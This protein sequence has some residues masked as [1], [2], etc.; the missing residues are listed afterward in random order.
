MLITGR[1]AREALLDAGISDR[2]A[3]TALSCGLAGPAVTT[4]AALL[5]ESDR[6][7]ELGR[8][9]IVTHE[10]LHER[11]PEGVFLTR[12]SVHV[13]CGPERLR[14]ELSTIPGQFSVLTMLGLGWKGTKLVATVA[15]FV[16]MGATIVSSRGRDLVLEEP[17]AWFDALAGGQLLTGKGRQWKL[18][19]PPPLPPPRATYVSPVRPLEEW[20]AEIDLDSDDLDPDW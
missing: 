19:T 5:Y 4:S 9:R 16:V 15:G 10:E 3:R 2:R 7:E 1:Q 6:V 14:A 12:R 20:D 18:L 11:C 8:R 13:V 17:G